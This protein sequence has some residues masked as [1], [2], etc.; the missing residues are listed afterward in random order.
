MLAWL[1]SHPSR[2][3]TYVANRTTQILDIV[4]AENW[5]YVDTKSNPADCAS[6]GLLPSE[7]IGNS[8][9]VDGPSIQELQLHAKFSLS[10]EQNNIIKDSIN[11]N[12]NVLL[13]KKYEESSFVKD[14]SSHFIAIRKI[15]YVS[16]FVVNI[17]EKII[18]KYTTLSKSGNS[19]KDTATLNDQLNK[20]QQLVY[21]L[22]NGEN[23]ILRLAQKSSYA[24]EIKCLLN[25]QSLNSKSKLKGLHPFLDKF[26]I[27]R[28]G[29]R[30]QNS[31]LSYSQKH[32]I[33]LPP[34]NQVTKNIIKEAHDLT[35]H[36][37][38]SLMLSYLRNKYHIS[39]VSEK[40]KSF[41]HSCN[42]CFRYSQTQQKQLMGSLPTNRVNF[43][44]PFQ[45]TGVDYAGPLTMKAYAGRCKIMLK[46]YIAVFVCLCTKA[47]HVELVTDL[48]S[49]GFLAAFKRFVLRRGRCHKL[50]S[51]NGKNFVGANRIMQDE[52]KSAEK[53]WKSELEI[54]FSKLGTEWHFIPP[55]SPNF[56]G[57]WEAG[58][59]SLKSHLKKTI[60]TAIFTYEELS[61][62][63]IQIEGVLNSRPLCKMSNNPNDYNYLTPGHFLVGEAIVAPLEMAYNIDEN[64]SYHERWNHVQQCFQRFVKLW[65]KDY[66]QNLQNRPKNQSEEINLKVD[67]LVM[68]TDDDMPPTLWPIV[69]VKEIHPGK[70]KKVRV[71]TVRTSNGKVFV[72]PISK[73]RYLPCN[74]SNNNSPSYIHDK[75][76]ND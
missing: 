37:S 44:R 43:S 40:V 18:L 52:L 3:K 75:I 13:V 32:P 33:I 10:D 59:K 63:L 5:N 50:Y 2:W 39:R 47:I 45:N 27:L 7:L 48:T 69:M 24:D 29:G 72:R 22:S 64:K 61:T 28:V 30:L 49:K 1:Q 73:L 9:W 17:L 55:A 6:R 19:V 68:L 74:N 11:K 57:L 34:N 14:Y 38:E 60:G 23:I 76:K 26:G 25:N 8:L 58:V 16:K 46:V 12:S 31:D 20:Y 21:N 15:S 70:D 56:G 65:K 51:D 4:K 42:V 41:I 36:G 54:K 67:D 35:L 66:L 53:T 62:I 71:A